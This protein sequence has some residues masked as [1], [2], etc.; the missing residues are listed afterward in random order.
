MFVGCINVL[1]AIFFYNNYYFFGDFIFIII[2]V[3]F[4]SYI[5]LIFKSFQKQM[6]YDQ[7]MFL[8]CICSCFKKVFLFL[9]LFLLIM[10]LINLIIL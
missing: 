8:I 4:I 3:L 6:H 1:Y 10:P 2:N 9:F 7:I 5:K